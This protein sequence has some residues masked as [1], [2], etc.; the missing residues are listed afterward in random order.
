MSHSELSQPGPRGPWRPS[1]GPLGDPA[2]L[3]SATAEQPG[4]LPSLQESRQA[5]TPL[6]SERGLGRGSSE[7]Q[8][9]CEM[10]AKVSK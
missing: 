8:Q 1:E 9:L 4:P 3:P 7:S 6:L 2:S 5:F 10:V